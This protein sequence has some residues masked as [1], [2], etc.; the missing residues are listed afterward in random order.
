MFDAV[1][2]GGGVTGAG[3]ARDLSLRGRSVLL[4]EKGDW[5]GGTS[6]ASSW[7]I[8]GGP[9]YL[10][11][12]WE[13]TRL[14][15]EDAGHIVDIA[16]HMVHRCVFLLPVLPGDRY[17]MERM[18]TAM[19]VYDRFQAL[20]RSYPHMR[21][22]PAGARKLEP[23]LSSELLGAITMEEWGV[24][25]HR[26]VWANV[27]D[28][29]RHGATCHN[30]AEVVGL[31]RDGSQVLGVRYRRGGAFHEARARL[32]VNAAGPWVPGVAAMAGTSVR[33]RP[34]KGIHVV[35]DRRI[36][37]FALSAEAVDGRELL[38]VPHGPISILG[39]TDDDYYG[40]LDAP[41]VLAEEVAY[42]LQGMERAFPAIRNYRPVR[43]TV[44]VR[45]TLFAWRSYEDDLSR[46][47][48]IIDHQSVDG[49][50]GLI[51][52]AG[53]KLSM[54]RLM[55]EQAADLVC[56]HLGV[57]APGQSARLPLPGAGASAPDPEEL[58]RAHG[59]PALAC[60]RLIERHGSEAEAVLSG[61]GR[62]GIVCRCEALTEAELTHAARHEQVVTLRDA[63]RRVGL[64][65]GPCAGAACV[66]RAAD[67]IGAEL[68]WSAAMRQ[69][70]VREHLAA[71]WRGRAPLLDRWGWAQEELAYG[72][73]R[74]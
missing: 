55:A 10:T 49:V 8:H 72:A 46:R 15:C 5:G 59:V 41:E 44:G 60:A 58:G 69:E 34:A 26:L 14:S 11:F 56:G 35:F 22:D 53:G 42:L 36:S 64:G 67:V 61:G 40:D 70:S 1:V 19:E 47:Y 9:R 71:S 32:V 13:T 21:L 24:D 25:P 65:S 45:P 16:R 20:K 3:I 54:Y 66:E 50:P 27:L 63:F 7:M 48:A 57:D 4:L 23:G 68:G 43:A 39:T 74:G 51:T 30:H 52:V 6:G 37:N 31:L 12:D 33:L 38:L 2:I 73:R 28:A 18:E 17:G 62:R 29:I